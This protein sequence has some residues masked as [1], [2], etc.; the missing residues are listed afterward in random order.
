M[1]WT[2][3]TTVVPGCFATTTD[4]DH[5]SQRVVELERVNSTVLADASAATKRLEN[6]ASQVEEASNQLRETLAKA[7]ARIAESDRSLQ[8][9][10]GELEV[11]LHR[12]DATERQGSS[13]NQS[14]VEV[15]GRLNQLIADLRDRA[16][17]AILA[18]PAEL[19]KD[20]DAF[21]RAADAAFADGDVRLAA[22]LAS[23][24]QKRYPGT[25]SWASCG[26][27]HGRI[28]AQEQRFVDALKIF[29]SVHDGLSGKPCAPVAQSLVEVAKILEAQ[30]K[31]AKATQV[32]TYL[33]SEMPKVPQAKQ[34]KA[35]PAL[36]AKRCKEGGGLAEPKA[37]DAKPAD[38]KPA[39]AKPAD[40]KPA[41]DAKP[42][43]DVK[44]GP[45]VKLPESATA[46]DLPG[47]AT[48]DKA[49]AAAPAKAPA[50]KP[51]APAVPAKPAPAPAKPAASAPKPA[52]AK[53]A[54]AKP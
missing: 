17:I 52:P 8:K 25:E 38:A 32:W 18:L 28:A 51:A 27:V 53:P 14:V 21:V 26:L 16:G 54:P 4:V 13:A 34:A 6:L 2:A 10:R 23:E 29:Q 41:P 11:I 42:A 7:N 50:A 47:A 19:P 39:D 12:L 40:A 3:L 20:A 1:A 45:A 22:A 5:V 37:P 44:P 46:T 33:A 30:G 15:R 48:V 43:A 9:L 35:E 36:I 49:K 24:C 31:C